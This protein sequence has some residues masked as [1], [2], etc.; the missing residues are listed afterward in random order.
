LPGD[1]SIN[2]A[3]PW[4]G[5]HHRPAPRLTPEE[6]RERDLNQVTYDTMREESKAHPEAGIEFMDAYEYL[7]TPSEAYL[8]LKGG[9]AEHSEN[10]RLLD[11]SEMPPNM[12]F[13]CKYTAWCL[14]PPV[15]CAFLMRRFL[16]RGGKV[17]R[18]RLTSLAEAASLAPNVEVVVNA[19]G[20]GFGDDPNVFPI[21][22]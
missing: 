1:E 11:K 12:K 2:Y 16:V 9:F 18:S 8:K 20:V 22:G 21:K 15:Y 19:S 4:A 17:V 5:A 7:E 14:N 10:F 13:G 3:S 6:E